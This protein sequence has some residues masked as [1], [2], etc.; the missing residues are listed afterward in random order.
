LLGTQNPGKRRELEALLA[1]LAAHTVTP[2]ELGL[3]GDV[4]ETGSSFA[5]NA[6]L[7][8]ET[9]ARV[10]GY[11]TLA[12]DSGL[13]VEA[14][15]GAP[16]LYSAR[17]AGPGAGDAGRRRKL[18]HELRHVPVPRRARFVCVLVVAAPGA[19]GGLDVREFE[20]ECPGEIAFEER[21]ENGFGYAP[22]FFLPDRGV[23]LA[24]LPEAEK[25]TLSHRGRAVAGALPYLLELF[26]RK[27]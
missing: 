4:P 15:G 9:L 1:D 2:A 26:G 23:T 22:L 20:G 11:V 12:D 24:E 19:A 27:T 7:K 6:R 21:G 3:S 8:A 17:Y 25:N 5:A 14:L 16:G 10:S 13:E 18:L